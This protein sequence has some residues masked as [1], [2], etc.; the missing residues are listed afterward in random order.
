MRLGFDLGLRGGRAGAVG[1]LARSG[2][3]VMAGGEPIGRGEDICSMSARR[4]ERVM[5]WMDHPDPGLDQHT[6]D[7]WASHPCEGPLRGVLANGEATRPLARVRI[8]VFRD[9]GLRADPLPT[10]WTFV[11]SSRRIERQPESGRRLWSPST[12]LGLRNI[13]LPR[14]GAEDCCRPRRRLSRLV[15]R[16]FVVPESVS[17]LSQRPKLTPCRLPPLQPS[18][19]RRRC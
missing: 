6:R 18:P 9:L 16:F 10:R 7:G 13:N 12:H 5:G 11:R 15:D 19:P 17:V 4:L 14:V 3:D 1:R 2:A 8:G